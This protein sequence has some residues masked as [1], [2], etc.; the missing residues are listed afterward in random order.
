MKGMFIGVKQHANTFAAEKNFYVDEVKKSILKVTALGTYFAEINGVRV[1]KDYL[2]PGWTSYNKTLQVQEYDVTDLLKKG[3]NEVAITVNEGW[4]CG[5]LTW[6][7][8]RDN[9]GKQ[10]AVCAE[11]TVGDK[12]I[13]TDES[14]TARESYIRES[15]IYHGEIADY[16]A[17]LKPL[18]ICVVP[19]DKTVLGPQQCEPVRDTDRLSVKEIF[20]D[21]D[22]KK[23]YDFGQNMAGVV[24]IVTPETFD[25]A[26]T[27]RFGELMVDGRLYTENLRKARATDSFTV[28][29]EKETRSGIYFPWFSLYGTYGRRDSD[30]KHYGDCQTYGYETNGEDFYF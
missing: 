15:G 24:E 27:L 21:P 8:T 19:F 23:I 20:I 3:E 5:P 28:K 14:W 6:D 22:G 13:V 2:A 29:G 30:R 26:L 1:G 9:Y 18:T 10:T 12:T 11:L 25:G 17:S 16:T 4:Y 7:L